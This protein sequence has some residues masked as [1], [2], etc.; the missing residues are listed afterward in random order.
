VHQDKRTPWL[1]TEVEAAGQSVPSLSCSIEF[2]Y[3]SRVGLLK[4]TTTTTTTTTIP[5]TT[6]V[7]EASGLTIHQIISQFIYN[8]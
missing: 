3:N 5:Q 6:N 1:T 2:N 7:L 4:T 8:L